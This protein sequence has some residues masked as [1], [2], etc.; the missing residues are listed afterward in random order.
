MEKL[1]AGLAIVLVFGALCFRLGHLPLLQPDEGR[2][3]E[4]AREMKESGAWLVP[5]YNGVDYLDKPAFY[6]KAVA[7]SLTWFGNSETAARL[8]SALFGVGLVIMVYAFCRRVYG[9]RGALL[10]VIVVATM[11]LYLSNSR[12]VIFDI[13]LAFFV[14]GAIFAGFL[15]EMEEGRARRNWYLLGALSAGFATL[16]KGPVGFLIP[17]LV[18]LVFNRIEG[19]RGAW[20][21]LLAPLNLLVFFGVTLPWFVGLCLAHRD[22]L[23]YGLVEE[24]FKR[25]TTAKRFHRSEPFYF[26][27]LITAGTFFPWSLLLPEASVASWKERWAR[28]SADR[29]CIVW[30]VLVIVFFS[31]SQSKLPGYILSVAV[32]C[33]ILVGRLFD[34]AL[35]Q[36]EGR[37]ARLAGRALTAFTVICLLVAVVVAVGA[38]HA[39]IFAKPLRIPDAEAARFEQAALGMGTLMAGFGVLGLLARYRRDVS[40]GFLSLSLFPALFLHVNTSVLEVIF[41]A[42][43]SR[44]L[45]RQLSSLPA[46]TELACLRC[47][48]CG[49]PFYLQRTATLI[50][51]DGGE[52][53]SNYIISRLEKE[54]Q[55]PQQIVPLT[56]FDDWLASRKKPVYLIVR[57]SDRSK[58]EGIAAARKTT[59]QPLLQGYLGAHLPAPGGP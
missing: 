34:E 38:S 31:V 26:Y 28:N 54:P 43:A 27:L 56:Q 32:S 22:F 50:S 30:S 25:F 4:V 5:T 12:T 6:F 47:F 41:D 44:Q 11:P 39:Q 35:Q 58:L 1:L 2:N 52:L 23:H 33:G 51:R 55:W 42:K 19:R 45:A 59:I 13:A 20:K 16:V 29:L 3:A 40:L 10:A 24:S 36:P 7:L 21:R 53:T 46:E 9:P 15:A 48:P 49:L 17:M 14:C 37:A 57:E 18:L 8:P